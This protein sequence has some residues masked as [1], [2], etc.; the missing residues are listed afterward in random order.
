MSF[1]EKLLHENLKVSLENPHMVFLLLTP[2]SSTP[3]GSTHK[4][5][6]AAFISRSRRFL[7]VPVLLNNLG[8]LEQLA[9]WR[10]AAPCAAAGFHRATNTHSSRFFSPGGPL[11]AVSDVNAMNDALQLEL[12][13]ASRKLEQS[14]RLVE[15]LQSDVS[16]LRKKL[17][18]KKK[19]DAGNGGPVAQVVHEAL[20]SL[21]ACPLCHTHTHTLTLEAFPV[22][23]VSQQEVDD[24]T[25]APETAS[26]MRPGRRAGGTL[27]GTDRKRRRSPSE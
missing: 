23:G 18:E 14:E 13:E 19:R 8:V 2:S 20:R 21:L 24:G 10:A 22:P 27:V 26:P 16:A 4:M 15:T 17:S 25:S 5:E 11:R 7:K 6:Y 12:Q 1:R 3:T 9:Y